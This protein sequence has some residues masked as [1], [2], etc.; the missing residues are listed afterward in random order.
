MTKDPRKALKFSLGIALA[1]VIALY[2]LDKT[3]NL[4]M[5]PEIIVQTPLNGAVV[6]STTIPIEGT[7]KNISKISINGRQI[8]I[9]QKGIFK[10]R[11]V[12]AKGYNIITVVGIDRFGKVKEVKVSAVA[13]CCRLSSMPLYLFCHLY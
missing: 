10:D 13:W 5:G 12:I 11:L 7:A 6:L 9:D 3:Q 2:A 1:L 4:L 8:S